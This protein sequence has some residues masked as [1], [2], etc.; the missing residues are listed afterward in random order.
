MT[1][2]Q[3]DSAKHPNCVYCG[4]R[5]HHV[6]LARFNDDGLCPVGVAFACFGPRKSRE[7]CDCS[8]CMCGECIA[9]LDPASKEAVMNYI[10]WS[11]NESDDSQ[12]KG[13]VDA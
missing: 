7:N 1:D 13:S 4:H 10:G 2:M 3:F 11:D 12:G 5:P 9:K 6:D 8:P